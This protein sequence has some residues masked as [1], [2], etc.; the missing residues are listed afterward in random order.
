MAVLHLAEDLVSA[1]VGL[2]MA[3]SWAVVAVAAVR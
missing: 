1:T 3:V 2:W